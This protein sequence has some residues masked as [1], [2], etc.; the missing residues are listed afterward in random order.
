MSAQEK[1]IINSVNIGNVK[2]VCRFRPLNE[3]EKAMG[4]LHL[5]ELLDD[6]T[7]AIKDK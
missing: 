2:V 6:K 4:A 7:V 1:N 3:K 5:H